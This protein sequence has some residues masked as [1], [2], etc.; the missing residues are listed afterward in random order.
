[1]ILVVLLSSKLLKAEKISIYFQVIFTAIS[2]LL[3]IFKV[4]DTKA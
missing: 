3:D 2:R 1:M 4:M